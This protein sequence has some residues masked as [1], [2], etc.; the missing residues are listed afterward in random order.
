MY[1][2]DVL[3]AMGVATGLGSLDVLIPVGGPTAAVAVVRVFNDA[4]AAGTS[5]FTEDFVIAEDVIG[6]GQSGYLI[7]PPDLAV[8]RFNVGVRTLG[9]GAS[10]T[11]KVRNGAGAVTK[12]LTKSYAANFFEQTPA[13]TFLGG[14]G[15]SGNQ[16]LT[17]RVTAGSAIV[18]GATV[19]NRTNDSSFQ[20]T[21]RLVD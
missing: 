9:Q 5:G 16:S 4:G 19:D 11:V 1:L 14:P 10:M 13:D 6:P 2:A 8:Y 3:P 18:Y 17:I 15:L 21:Q 12:T 7:G 20:R